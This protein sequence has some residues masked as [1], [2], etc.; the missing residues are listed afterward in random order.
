MREKTIFIII[1]IITLVVGFAIRYAVARRKF[2]RRAIT[3]A[4]VFRSYERAWSITLAEKLAK[5]IA[6]ILI[7]IGILALLAVLTNFGAT[8]NATR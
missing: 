6:N 5:L 3:G 1:S 7:I 8:F 2:K 4:E